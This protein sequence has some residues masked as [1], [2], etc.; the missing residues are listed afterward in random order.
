[1]DTFG[2]I[3]ACLGLL[4]YMLSCLWLTIC[5]FR[6][7]IG[8]GFLF[9]LVPFASLVYI[10]MDWSRVSRPALIAVAALM[11]L[12]AGTALSPTVQRAFTNSTISGAK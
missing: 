2:V 10:I 12:V 1:M 8:W 5:A 6:K 7:S 4:V 3:L 11:V 9:I